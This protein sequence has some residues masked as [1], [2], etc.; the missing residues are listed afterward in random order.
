MTGVRS[1]V[2]LILVLC[3]GACASFSPRPAETIP[4]HD[5]IQSQT[6]G[7]LSVAAAALSRPETNALLGRPV[8]GQ[9]IQAVWLR[10][11][12]QTAKGYLLA[13]RM[14]D[15]L[16]YSPLEAATL[17]SATFGGDINERIRQHFV[18]LAIDTFVPAGRTVEGYV[19][20]RFDEGTKPLSVFLVSTRDVK[21]FVFFAVVPGLDLDYQAVGLDSL[22]RSDEIVDMDE[23]DLRKT[24]SQFACCVTNAEEN[25]QGDPLNL[26]LIGEARHIHAALIYSGWDETERVGVASSWETV[27]S[28][29]FGSPY[30]YS[31]VSPLYVFGR[32]QDA[33][34]QKTRVGVNE[35]NHL[36]VWLTP[37]RL[38][39]NPVWIGAISRDIDVKLTTR[40]W[41][42]TTHVIDPDLDSERWYLAQ[43]LLFSQTVTHIGWVKGAGLS[44]AA[45]PRRNLTDDPYFTDGMRL[46]VVVDGNL[47]SFD[48]LEFF[49][50]EW[51]VF[52]NERKKITRF[53]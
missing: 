31:P 11:T 26:V 47:T 3:L 22:Y 51:P 2:A 18:K 8:D 1:C 30:R 23:E 44:T 14:L 9:D 27:K 10:I 19:F 12:N 43:D 37:W 36:R 4:F 24:L 17:G 41:N 42:L 13:P 25:R 33:A 32:P 16:Y 48:E 45:D 52:G 53:R 7:G 21:R 28:F 46:I 20:T 34:L 6:Q 29:L 35:R 38:K 49:D 40:T 39:G 5:R 50:W 15:P